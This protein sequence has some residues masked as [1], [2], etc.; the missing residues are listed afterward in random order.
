MEKK[1]N[2][3]Y[4]IIKNIFLDKI[5]QLTISKAQNCPVPFF[6]DVSC[7]HVIL[8]S[9]TIRCP[10]YKFF[11]FISLKLFF[12]VQRQLEMLKKEMASI[13]RNEGKMVK[14]VEVCKEKRVTSSCVPS[15]VFP[16]RERAQKTASWL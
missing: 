14:I 1:S 13:E 6:K 10:L 9:A 2:S 11:L 15:H 16:Q 8:Y 4:A 3:Q 5:V 12:L 7:A